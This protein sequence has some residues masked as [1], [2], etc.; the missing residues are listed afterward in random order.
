MLNVK[1]AGRH[2]CNYDDSLEDMKIHHQVYLYTRFIH[3][4]SNI[5]MVFNHTQ[6]IANG[7]IVTVAYDC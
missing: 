3:F 7:S 6:S 5:K 1:T 2:V 4:N